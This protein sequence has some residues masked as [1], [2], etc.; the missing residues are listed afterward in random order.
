MNSKQKQ[1][2]KQKQKKKQ[3]RSAQKRTIRSVRAH[4]G[5]TDVARP[6]FAGLVEDGGRSRFGTGPGLVFGCGGH[7]DLVSVESVSS[8]GRGDYQ[9]R[10]GGGGMVGEWR[11][12]M[13]RKGR[14]GG[15]G[16]DP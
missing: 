9:I 1:K 8:V 3:E 10:L 16:D 5:R 13:G 4:R 12:G 15:R 2:Q 11:G 6:E 7:H 14:R